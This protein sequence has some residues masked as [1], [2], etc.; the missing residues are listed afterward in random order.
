MDLRQARGEPWYVGR[1]G[2][3]SARPQRTRKKQAWMVAIALL[4]V[5][6]AASCRKEGKLL[7]GGTPGVTVEGST[8]LLIALPIVNKGVTD[9]H[10]VRVREIELRGGHL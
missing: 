3:M 9:A 6:I 10:D 4:A 2:L 8:E 5:S 7:D 1:E